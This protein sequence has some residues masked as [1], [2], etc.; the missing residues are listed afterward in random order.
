L[1][2][3]WSGSLLVINSFSFCLPGTLLISPFIMNKI[4]AG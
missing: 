1:S 2:I 4:F 3:F